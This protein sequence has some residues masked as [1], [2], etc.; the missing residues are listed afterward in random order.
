M[1]ERQA[2]YPNKVTCKYINSI[3]TFNFVF[4]V[5]IF[6][7]KVEDNVGGWDIEFNLNWVFPRLSCSNA[8]CVLHFEK[9]ILVACG[10]GERMRCSVLGFFSHTWSPLTAVNAPVHIT[11]FFPLSFSHTHTQ[12]DLHTH[13]RCYLSPH[14]VL[15][16]CFDYSLLV[17]TEASKLKKNDI[18]CMLLHLQ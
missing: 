7:L 8:S 14:R 3:L 15:C 9:L 12:T 10:V 1:N 4:N 11:F 17:T 6:H 18:R 2:D 13:D 5:I 16:W